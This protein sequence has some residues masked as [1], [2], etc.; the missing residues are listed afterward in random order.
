[1][2][3]IFEDTSDGVSGNRLVRIFEK[4]SLQNAAKLFKITGWDEILFK[5]LGSIIQCSESTQSIFRNILAFYRG[6]EDFHK[7]L[8]D[9][10]FELRKNPQKNKCHKN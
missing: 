1:M 2:K 6:N 9:K 4:K 3:A 7:S 10:L 5:N 8:I